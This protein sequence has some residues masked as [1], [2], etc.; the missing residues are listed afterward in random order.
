LAQRRQG[1]QDVRE[2]PNVTNIS[3]FS[4]RAGCR[5]LTGEEAE[6]MSPIVDFYR[7]EKTDYLGRRLQDI[8]LWDNDRL[9]AVHNY[10][11]VLFPNREQS[12]FNAS[13][14]LLDQATIDAFLRDEQLRANLATSLDVM[15]RFYGLEFQAESGEVVKRP[16]FHERARNWINPYNHNYL[17]ITRILKCLVD[18]GLA[19]RACALF[20]CLAGIYRESKDAIG[21][22]AFGYWRDAVTHAG[23]RRDED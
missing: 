18:L 10:I 11:Q 6:G 14:P 7:G 23:A 22:D 2:N 1:P 15:L 13:A 3:L 8:W 20:D 19:R 16:D 17:R 12:Q 21:P 9:E 4:F 5:T